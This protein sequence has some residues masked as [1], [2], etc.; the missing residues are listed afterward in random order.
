MF[1]DIRLPGI[2]IAGSA[3]SAE[4]AEELAG[5]LAQLAKK[6]VKDEMKH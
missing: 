6:A 2:I 4:V 5:D 3:F 1:P